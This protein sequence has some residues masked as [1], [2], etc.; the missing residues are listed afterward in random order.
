MSNLTGFE[1]KWGE[2]SIRTHFLKHLLPIQEKN[3][4]M[5]TM[6]SR[7]L[8][9]LLSLVSLGGCSNRLADTPPGAGPPDPAGT[10]PIRKGYP[11]WEWA[12]YRA[13][14]KLNI[15]G[16]D[17]AGKWATPDRATDLVSDTYQLPKPAKGANPNR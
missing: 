14:D 6:K 3:G 11:I 12:P 16:G 17:Y 9:C 7:F 1:T 8:I 4:K 2:I 13:Q 15:T 10:R 5:E